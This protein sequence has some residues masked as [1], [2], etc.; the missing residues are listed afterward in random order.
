[1]KDVLGN[2][3]VSR[4]VF[5]IGETPKKQTVTLRADGMTLVDGKPFYL[6]NF[7]EMTDDSELMEFF[8][9][10]TYFQ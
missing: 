6:K 7:S 5:L 4:K 10:A 2:A 9:N 8:E 3:T 1:M